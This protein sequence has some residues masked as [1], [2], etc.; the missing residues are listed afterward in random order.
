[1][2]SNASNCTSENEAKKDEVVINGVTYHQCNAHKLHYSIANYDVKA[3]GSLVDGKGAYGGMSGSDVHVLVESSIKADVIG[4]GE[5]VIKDLN[6]CTIAGLIN[7]CS[8]PVIGI[9]HQY[10]HYG[11]GKTVNSVPQLS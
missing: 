11:E 8:G 6:I 7:T 10:A 4:V 9:F 1:M 2:L 3:K 5:N